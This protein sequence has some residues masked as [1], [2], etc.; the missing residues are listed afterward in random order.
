MNINKVSKVKYWGGPGPPYPPPSLPFLRPWHVA[1]PITLHHSGHTHKQL[2]C[3]KLFPLGIIVKWGVFMCKISWFFQWN[4]VLLDLALLFVC[5]NSRYCMA[6]SFCWIKLL[7]N[8]G[9][10]HFHKKKTCVHCSLVWLKDALPP[11]SYRKFLQIVS[12]PRNSWKFSSSKVFC[13]AV[14]ISKSLELTLSM[15]SF[16]TGFQ[17]NPSVN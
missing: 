6:E 13:Y 8:G 2:S 1:L 10:E 4:Y 14:P 3:T 16:V 7:Q 11:N 12:K 17:S 9:K 15:K 5:G